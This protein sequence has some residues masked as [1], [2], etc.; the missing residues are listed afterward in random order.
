MKIIINDLESFKSKRYAINTP[1]PAPVKGSGTATKNTRDRHS[2]LCIFLSALFLIFG[3]ILYPLLFY[4][5]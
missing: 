3:E 4:M 5:V 1:K 2:Y